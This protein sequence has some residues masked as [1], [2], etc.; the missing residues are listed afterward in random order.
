MNIFKTFLSFICVISIT[1]SY[2]VSLGISASANSWS[3]F[4]TNIIEEWSEQIAS[5]GEYKQAIITSAVIFGVSWGIKKYRHYSLYT[6][7]RNEDFFNQ[8]DLAVRVKQS[9]GEANV[10]FLETAK[11]EYRLFKGVKELIE[12]LQVIFVGEFFDTVQALRLVG[13]IKLTINAISI[14]GLWIS[15]LIGAPY[16]SSY[17]IKTPFSA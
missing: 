3:K 10:T 11:S 7:K 12:Q 16:A 6:T 17:A 4:F 15:L 14:Q 9:H 1:Y 2:G 13:D 5:V 8:L